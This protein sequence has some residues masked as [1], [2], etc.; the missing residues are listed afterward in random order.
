MYLNFH[1]VSG[2]RYAGIFMKTLLATLL[3]RYEFHSDLSTNEF[4]FEIELSLKLIGG[5][6]IRITPRIKK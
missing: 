1:N 6:L 5:H 2:I 3:C 4:R